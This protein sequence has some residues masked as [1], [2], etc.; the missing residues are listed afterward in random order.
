MRAR[1]SDSDSFG[2]S[3]GNNGRSRT[4]SFRKGRRLGQKVRGI[5]MKWVSDDMAWVNIDDHRLLAQLQSKPPVGA[6]LTFIIKQLQPDIILKEVFEVA[7]TAA[8]AISIANDYDT[9]RTLFENQ[10]RP[11]VAQIAATSPQHRLSE[12]VTLMGQDTKLLSSYLDAASCLQVI[13][14]AVGKEK[15]TLHYSPWLTPT[16]RRHIGVVHPPGTLSEDTPITKSTEECEFQSLGMVRTEFMRKNGNTAYRLLAQH[17]RHNADLK[18]Y[19][20]TRHHS[21]SADSLEFLGVAK[22]PPGKHGGLIAELM[23]KQ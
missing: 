14:V 8:N 12:F 2:F 23:F 9:A 21:L 3:D 1:K 11:Y 5:L 15:G 19:L 20:S 10:F 18:R 7:G 22:L 13:Q 17:V 4:E 6:H 16:A